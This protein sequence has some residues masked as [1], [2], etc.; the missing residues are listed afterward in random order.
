MTKQ[1]IRD[2]LIQ[3]FKE[4]TKLEEEAF[5]NRQELEDFVDSLTLLE[6]VFK[7][8]NKFNIEVDDEKIPEM[9]D[10]EDVVTGVEQ[11][12]NKTSA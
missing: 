7:I 1:N 2:V 11:L 8:E 3:I 5:L 9:K 12:L 4:E 6:I 10:F